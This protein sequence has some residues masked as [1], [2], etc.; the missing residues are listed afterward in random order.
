MKI[1]KEKI[2]TMIIGTRGKTGIRIDKEVRYEI[3][4]RFG[5]RGRAYTLHELK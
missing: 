2:K 1:N 5:K 4:E 3:N